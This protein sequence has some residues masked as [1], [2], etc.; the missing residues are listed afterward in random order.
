MPSHE[1]RFDTLHTMLTAGLVARLGSPLPDD[2]ILNLA[3]A[4]STSG[5]M[6]GP[7]MG[8]RRAAMWIGNVDR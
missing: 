1:G 5:G 4:R 6:R 7:R 2:K 8:P 3:A